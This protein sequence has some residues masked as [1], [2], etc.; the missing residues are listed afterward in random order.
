M[1]RLIIQGI[2]MYQRFGRH[3]LSA[4]PFALPVSGCRSWPTCSDYAIRAISERGVLRGA[5]VA[6]LRFLK[7]NPFAIRH[8][9]LR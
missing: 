7:C 6:T 8:A 5:A 2:R 1:K 4:S 9:T 3:L